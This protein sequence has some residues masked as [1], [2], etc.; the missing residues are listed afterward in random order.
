MEIDIERLREDLINYLGTAM[1]YQ[2]L[3]MMDLVQIE[4]MSPIELI[5][6]AIK[7]GFDLEEYKNKVR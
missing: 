4:M 1:N 6:F 3:A 5:D 7:N 2:E